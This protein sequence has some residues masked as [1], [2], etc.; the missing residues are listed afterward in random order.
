MLSL[1]EAIATGKKFKRKGAADWY[2]LQAT[3]NKFSQEDLTSKDYFTPSCKLSREVTLDD[4]ES[5]YVQIN[6]EPPKM[7]RGA[8]VELVKILF[9]VTIK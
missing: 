9:D 6:A 1:V 7:S 3:D 5:A 8:F 4:L 2:N